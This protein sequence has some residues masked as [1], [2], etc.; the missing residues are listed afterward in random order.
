MLII[1]VNMPGLLF[2]F[3]HKHWSLFQKG[4]RWNF[5]AEVGEDAQQWPQRVTTSMR[6]WWRSAVTMG[7]TSCARPSASRLTVIIA[8]T[9]YGACSLR[10]TPAKVRFTTHPLPQYEYRYMTAASEYKYL[11]VYDALMIVL[12]MLSYD[13]SLL[14]CVSFTSLLIA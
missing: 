5:S 3:F 14:V 7:T 2:S 13:A 8:A 4:D 1:C 11:W 6:L 10:G 12:S 9:R